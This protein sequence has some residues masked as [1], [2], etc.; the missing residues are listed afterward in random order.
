MGGDFA[1]TTMLDRFSR[2]LIFHL[3]HFT[4]HFKIDVLLCLTY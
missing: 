4:E 3:F 2:V 1:V